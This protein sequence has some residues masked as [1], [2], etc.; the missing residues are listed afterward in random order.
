[1]KDEKIA[2]LMTVISKIINRHHQHLTRLDGPTF[3]LFELAKRINRAENEAALEAI[4][5][6]L[7]EFYQQHR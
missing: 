5:K 6:D 1:M 7:D 2:A 4:L 3:R